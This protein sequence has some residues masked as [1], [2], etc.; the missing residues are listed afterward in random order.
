V[1]LTIYTFGETR[2]NSTKDALHPSSVF[3]KHARCLTAFPL[4]DWFAQQFLLQQTRARERGLGRKPE[5][6]C[7]DEVGE[8]THEVVESKGERVENGECLYSPGY[9]PVPVMWWLEQKTKHFEIAN[10]ATWLLDAVIQS[11]T[12]ERLFKDFTRFHTKV[13]SRLKSRTVQK[14]TKVKRGM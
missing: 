8:A 9:D 2:W 11:A 10:W 14:I 1:A 3:V 12:C 5:S 6:D 13:R 4:S 7:L